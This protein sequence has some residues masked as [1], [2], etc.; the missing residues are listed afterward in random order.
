MLWFRVILTCLP[1]VGY[2]CI[3]LYVY[4]FSRLMALWTT[5]NFSGQPNFFKWLSALFFGYHPSNMWC[6]ARIYHVFSDF[7]QVSLFL[8]NS[9]HK[10]NLSLGFGDIFVSVAYGCHLHIN[11]IKKGGGADLVFLLSPFEHV[12][13]SAYLPRFYSNFR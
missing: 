10:I 11:R 6:V 7:C 8:N 2:I 12:I 4:G 9:L 5:I 1:H 13:C 3:V